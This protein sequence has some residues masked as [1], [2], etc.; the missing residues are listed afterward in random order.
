[1]G[2]A[3]VSHLGDTWNDGFLSVEI[4]VDDGRYSRNVGLNCI[5]S[6]EGESEDNQSEWTENND[7]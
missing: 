5:D 2:G 3:A 4:I 7:K 1:M 6:R